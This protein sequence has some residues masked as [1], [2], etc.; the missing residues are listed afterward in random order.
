MW[1]KIMTKKILLDHLP[2]VNLKSYGS[3][4]IMCACGLMMKT[5]DDKSWDE[6]AAHVEEQCNKQSAR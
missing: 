3:E 1:S 6:W 2:R 4:V 5:D